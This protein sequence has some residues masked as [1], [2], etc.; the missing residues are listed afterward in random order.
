MEIDKLKKGIPRKLIC[1][2]TVVIICINVS[3]QISYC[4]NLNFGLGNFTNWEGYTWHYTT[5]LD[6]PTAIPDTGIVHR[7]H[8]IISDTNAYD[9][10]TGNLLKLVPPGYK[11]AA[12][13]GDST[14]VGDTIVRNWRQSLRYKLQV[15]SSNPLLVLKFA[16]V[17]KNLYNH[18][19][20]SEHHFT[21][22]IL[23]SVGNLRTSCVNFQLCNSNDLFN[24]FQT[25]YPPDIFQLYTVQWLDWTTV[26]SDLSDFIGQNI[27]IEI[28]T[29]DCILPDSSLIGLWYSCFGY[30]YF[31]ADCQPLEIDQK[32]CD[33]Q[34]HSRLTA[35]D[36]FV[37]YRWINENGVN[38]GNYRTLELIDPIEGAEY[39]CQMI[40]VL[41]CVTTIS[42]RI[43]NPSLSAS[44]NADY[45]CDSNIVRFQNTSTT[46]DGQLYYSWY[47]GDGNTS[48]ERDPVYSYSTSGVHEVTLYIMNSLSGCTNKILKQVESF[49]PQTV[50]YD[51]ETTYCPGESTWINGYGT[52]HYLWSNGKSDDSIE[53]NAPGGEFWVIASTSNYNCST[54]TMFFSVSEE[55]DWNFW[56]FGDT[57]LCPGEHS[58]LLAN[59]S[60]QQI[61]NDG[62]D[63]T[64]IVV[65]DSGSYACQGENLRGCK[66]SASI[67]VSL[68]PIPVAEFVLSD[69]IVNSR[70]SEITATAENITGVSYVWDMGDGQNYLTGNSVTNNYDISYPGKIYTC[71]LEATNEFG[72][73]NHASDEI[74][75]I[76]FIPNVFSPNGDNINDVFMEGTDLEIFDRNGKILYKGTEGW[77][78]NYKGQPVDP[79]TYF[80]SITYSVKGYRIHPLKGY[81]TLV[82]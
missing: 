12:R 31:V 33:V 18:F 67:H 69:T 41:G 66:K 70:N 56:I 42:T 25:Y 6:E 52:S 35:P 8:E 40:S 54:D 9:P 72:C 80:Y 24:N 20:E 43:A 49:S 23:D 82:R 44:F 51:G 16:F 73:I 65:S 78:G 17:A 74:V 77:D 7:R 32:N 5:R 28:L 50:G 19:G 27:T 79:D 14:T 3:S 63:T 38:V 53:I 13:L 58:V 11:F 75:V 37:E 46:S 22:S 60:N 55:P 34:S 1:C 26:S 29:E 10:N 57:N 48:S 71:I 4:E 30:S 64:F 62:T 59:G 47:F 2:L 36:G 61:W 81:I 39:T 21:F 15:D 68:A 76:P 45:S